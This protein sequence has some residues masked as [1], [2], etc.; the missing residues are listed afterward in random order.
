[1]KKQNHDKLKRDFQGTYQK[2]ILATVIVAIGGIAL[3]YFIF[4]PS[5]SA[6]KGNEPET[7]IVEISVEDDFD[8]NFNESKIGI[9]KFSK[10]N[11]DDN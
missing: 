11:D 5:L 9:N 3:I 7:E 1:M 4:D 8:N 10:F 2:I 6:F